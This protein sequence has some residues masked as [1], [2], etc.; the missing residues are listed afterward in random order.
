MS[1]WDD[2]ADTIAVA[3]DRDT[4]APAFRAGYE[5]PDAD[6]LGNMWR[7]HTA[8]HAP[9]ARNWRD[10]RDAAWAAAGY[11]AAF[12]LAMLGTLFAIY[13]WGALAPLL[14]GHR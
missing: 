4:L 5:P 9:Q 10:A 11:A 3:R 1:E 2:H 8:R 6:P 14:G 13:A 7:E 12:A